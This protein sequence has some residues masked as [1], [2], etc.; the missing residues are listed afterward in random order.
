MAE[1]DD[2]TS[3]RVAVRIRPQSAK[4]RI[5][6][7]RIC[8]FVPP[9]E[10]QLTIG[11][12]KRFT[13]DY[14]FDLPT[15]QITI[16]ETCV[17]KLVDGCFNGYNATVLA[18]GQT[19]SGKTYTMG[20][21]FDISRCE[22][23][24]GVIPRAVDQIFS[25]IEERKQKALDEELPQPEFIISAQFME[26]Y[27]DKI[28]DLFNTRRGQGNVPDIKITK[29]KDGNIYAVGM[30]TKI[31]KSG[32]ELMKCL[33]D[34][35]LNRTTASTRMNEQSS[36][37]HAIFSIHIKQTRA[38]RAVA[39]NN[40]SP[41][42][43]DGELVKEN[44]ITNGD[45]P[46]EF[47]SLM[48]KFHFTDLAGSERLDRT[49]A[50]GDRAKEGIAINTGLLALGNVISALGDPEQS[51]SFVRYRD[52]KLTRLLQDSLG[53]NSRTLMIACISPSDSDFMET[54]STLNYANR[55][56]NIKNKVVLNQDKASQQ[57]QVLR[58]TIAALQL[59]ITE[60]KT[61][62]RVAG[63]EGYSDMYQENSML[64][65]ENEHLR[66]RV[67]VISEKC[68]TLL[69]ELTEL[70]SREALGNIDLNANGDVDSETQK[71]SLIKQYIK[72]NEELKSKL[73]ESEAMCGNLRRRGT[74]L[75][76]SAMSP[77]GSRVT[78]TPM[79]MAGTSFFDPPQENIPILDLA[80]KE[81]E[82]LRQKKLNL[83]RKENKENVDNLDEGEEV[84]DEDESEDESDAE[85]YLPDTDEE[86]DNEAVKK[87]NEEKK[88]ENVQ[89]QL[90]TLTFEIDL[91]QNLI[92]ELESQKIKM[93]TLRSSYE[94]KVKQLQT[95]IKNTEEE[96]DK[97]LSNLE[98]KPTAGRDS[99]KIKQEYQ[100][101]LDTMQKEVGKLKAQKKSYDKMVQEQFKDHQR[102]KNLKTEL[103]QMKSTKVKLM[104]QM[105]EQ[106]KKGKQQDSQRL[107]EIT[108]LRK[109]GRKKDSQLRTLETKFQAKDRVVKRN[110]E[111]IEMLRKQIRP[112][113][114]RLGAKRQAQQA[115][116][117]AMIK[118]RDKKLSNDQSMR[119]AKSKWTKI[120]NKI[121]NIVMQR[122][123]IEHMGKRM[124]RFIKQREDLLKNIKRL[125]KR[126]MKKVSIS[127]QAPAE[128]ICEIESLKETIEFTNYQIEEI[129]SEMLQVNESMEADSYISSIFDTCSRSEF[130]YI[131]DSILAI[132]VNK[133]ALSLVSKNKIAE[134]EAKLESELETSKRAQELMKYIVE[135]SQTELDPDLTELIAIHLILYGT[136]YDFY[137][138]G[139]DD[140]SDSDTDS[141][142][143]G[144]PSSRNELVSNP[145]TPTKDLRIKARAKTA[146][147]QELLHGI[148]QANLSPVSPWRMSSPIIPEEQG[149]GN[150]DAK[151]KRL[152]F[153]VL[154]PPTSL[155][156][157]NRPVPTL[158]SPDMENEVVDGTKSVLKIVTTPEKLGIKESPSEE[159]ARP[160]TPPTSRPV[161][162]R[163]HKMPPD[164]FARL[165]SF[166]I[167]SPHVKR[168]KMTEHTSKT[169]LGKNT[170]LECIKIAEGHSKAVLCLHATDQLLFSGS[171]DRTVKIWNLVTGQEFSTLDGHPNN[172][173]AVYHCP[174][175]GL[176]Y[177]VS[178]SFI[179]VWDI[180][181][182][183]KCIRIFSSSGQ[184]FPLSAF[185]S[186]MGR[187]N[188]MP[189]NESEIT[190]IAS[191][192][193]S[194][195]LY[196]ATGST[197][198][199]WDLN[200]YA[201]VGK[202]TGHGGQVKTIEVP[203]V[204]DEI[205]ITGSKDHYVK[206]F[207]IPES[208]GNI[209]PTTTFDPPHMDGV[210]SLA[211]SVTHNALFS[212]SR[213][214]SIK[215]WDLSSKSL[216]KSE[217]LAHT[218]WVSTLDMVNFNGKEILLSGG[219][220][221]IVKLWDVGSLSVVGD[222][223]AHSDTV[224]DIASNN[225]L[226]F[227][228]SNDKKIRVWRC[229][230][231][232]IFAPP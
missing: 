205:I 159:F 22:E 105:K 24:F 111:E 195:L 90:G 173:N 23:E 153:D 200:K 7:C 45:G 204:K 188:R 16:Y 82:E 69:E 119:W 56:R 93:E 192:K 74:S 11:K 42:S 164:V 126:K 39:K 28:I 146:T 15:Q 185:S 3:V 31:V 222:L 13:Y 162:N 68:D 12:N 228:A 107:R 70:K 62:K 9:G 46:L 110:K 147:P 138:Y 60:F 197:V 109:E 174:I 150:D 32:T 26:L 229:T 131:L 30:T 91:K 61:G 143:T 108:Q 18:Y 199:I 191:S 210:E 72:E 180:R 169:P 128:L 194:K 121:H 142:S 171:K 139:S 152:T 161:S 209:S 83:M 101:K 10:P 166:S 114:G 141:N 156:L 176:V 106:Q 160:G 77:F 49:G 17:R 122:E 215:K 136:S 189:D 127:Q 95:K 79:P 64:K 226:I 73:F 140:D 154:N 181:S 47:E 133:S 168:G 203:D 53:G 96:R 44:G 40:E 177:T 193:K 94:N 98:K 175:N 211:T 1:E 144:R 213:D 67:K 187:T 227:T 50:V 149:G 134:L 92:D 20:T 182:K 5:N 112:L 103:E 135:E 116:K 132:T 170:P 102:L 54:V 2:G 21:G 6:D 163:Q 184:N 212:C 196:T 125:E 232:S 75:S 63:D 38:V 216:I 36:R 41:T 223:R 158:P 34:G 84:I 123:T 214:K 208:H 206:S 167:G 178:L 81:I 186:T 201:L 43:S 87:K 225:E 165:T 224:N 99:S 130:R 76:S 117:A 148:T 198:K 65:E 219:R 124:D 172:V 35:A 19:G 230:D 86:D 157:G 202:L 231:S 145:E 59:E 183:P 89:N 115:S 218:S 48:A 25:G 118:N 155:E 58:Q 88:P 97:V 57:M 4:E 137:Q 217:Y 207:L 78:P 27:N 190:D 120:E 71:Q 85:V 113:S 151:S 8:T 37:S 66:M 14:V 80:K 220:D 179:K 51:G 33:Q 104:K 100:K 221:G 129:Q 29:D 52:S 55:A